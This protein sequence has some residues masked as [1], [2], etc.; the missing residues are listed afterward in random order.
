MTKKQKKS[1]YRILSGGIIFLFASLLPLN[2]PFLELLVFLTAYVIS[3]NDVIVKA[4]RNI[5]HGQIFDENFLMTLATAGAFCINQFQEGVAV[6]LFYQ[7]GELF[8][9]IAV[10]RSRRSIAELMDIRPDYANIEQNGILIQTDPEEIPVGS[11]I[12][13]KPGEKIPLDGIILSGSSLLD[14]KVLTGESV[15]KEVFKGCE[16]LSGC[17]NQTGLLRIKVTKEFQES[18][19]SKILD[20]VENASSKKSKS[21]NFITK[22]AK[23]YTP[24]VVISAAVLAIVPPLFLPEGGF[25][26]WVL[27]ALTFLVI[28]CPCALV[29]SVPLSFFG[30]IGGA[31]KLGILVKGSNFLELLAHTEVVVFDKTGT[32]TKG[33][34]QVSE[35]HPVGISSKA[36][37]EY[38]A[39]AEYYSSHP[40]SMSLKQ[41]YNHSFDSASI[42]DVREYS[43]YGVKAN[44]N[45]ISVTVGNQ[46]MMHFVS[47]FKPVLHPYGTIVYVAIQNRYAGYLVVSDE[48]R[49][50]AVDAIL[51]LKQN[52]VSRIVML[53]GDHASI[54]TSIGRHLGIDEICTDL[55]PADKVAKVE[56]LLQDTSRKGKLVFVGDGTNDA[57][58]LSRAD[59]G[60]AMGAIGSDAAIEAADIVL[61]NDEPG[62]LSDGI[63]IARRTLRIVYQNII[64]AL[65][66]KAAVLLLGACGI[67]DMWAA[68]F[69]DVGVSIIA[70]LNSMRNLHVHKH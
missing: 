10:N 3:G 69:A 1:L 46:K 58:V 2:S 7:I 54:G 20:L 56:A 34:F 70:I 67:A 61:M 65:G 31:S 45:G 13:V 57:P 22:F 39:K 35:I 44:I 14:M 41:A 43:G 23:Y 64:F 11:T 25:A 24:C 18:T 19:V 5:G 27:R 33:S 60:I 32:L 17:I 51:S 4:V 52:K 42:T 12:I 30:G 55:L 29:I 63:R 49:P 38:A 62:K 47:N 59:I 40:I 50:D 6:M 36:L 15:P 68:V 28:S 26:P 37:L 48:L 16:V 8:Q 9:S 53:T 21:E 66:I